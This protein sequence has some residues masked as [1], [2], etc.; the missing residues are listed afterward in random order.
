MI[1]APRAAACR[2][3][4]DTA[5]IFSS[6]SLEEASCRAA[7]VTWVTLYS[8]RPDRSPGTATCEYL[9]I[10][11]VPDATAHALGICWL[12]DR[13][14]VGEGQGVEV[15]VD[16]GGTRIIKNKTQTIRRSKISNKE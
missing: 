11:D 7:T 15:S 1:F 4:A 10:S 3:W 5:A 12:I 9:P 2:T 16:L 14:K 8:V 6:I 13:K